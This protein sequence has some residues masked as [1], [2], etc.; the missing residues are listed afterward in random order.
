MTAGD[1]MTESLAT[2]STDDGV[3]EATGRLFDHSVR[4][5]PVVDSDG[6]V[7]GIVSLDDL[8]V[9]LTDVLGNLAGVIEAESPPY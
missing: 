1:I 5:L 9:L 6:L 8:V 3:F 2:V 4:R 7:T